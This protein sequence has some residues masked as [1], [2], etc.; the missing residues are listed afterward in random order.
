VNKFDRWTDE[1]LQRL[2]AFEQET[3]HRGLPFIYL[4]GNIRPG[5]GFA[6]GP[7][8]KKVDVTGTSHVAL[9]DQAKHG[10]ARRDKGRVVETRLVSIFEEI[11]PRPSTH[12]DQELWGQGKFGLEDPWKRGMVELPLLNQESGQLA[13]YRA[14]TVFERGPIPGLVSVFRKERRRPIVQLNYVDDSKGKRMPEFKVIGFDEG[15]DDLAALT[16]DDSRDANESSVSS[17]DVKRDSSGPAGAPT[18]PK[19]GG[20]M[21][22][23]IPF[24]V[25]WR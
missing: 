25:E 23:D 18:K 3:S 16:A 14:E 2:Q 24:E 10:W 7:K 5:C 22:D 9:I 17:A 4:D 11:P 13:R 21:D 20:D 1:E 6:M 15:D 12:A 19:A 8:D